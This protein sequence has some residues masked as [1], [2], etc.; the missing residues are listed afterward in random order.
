M[1]RAEGGGSGSVVLQ[2]LEL[3]RQRRGVQAWHRLA[4]PVGAFGQVNLTFVLP[5]TYAVV[6][7]PCFVA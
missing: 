5:T 3:D 4:A 6:K 2:I 1:G 7:S